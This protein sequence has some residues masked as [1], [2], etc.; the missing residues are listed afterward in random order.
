M[1]LIDADALIEELGE[2]PFVWND[3]DEELTERNMWR[4][5]MS[6]VESAPTINATPY[7][8]VSTSG[9]VE[10]VEDWIEIERKDDE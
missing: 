2:E 6:L 1:R 9:Y 8:T 5:F 4:W 7:T 10:Q 3:T